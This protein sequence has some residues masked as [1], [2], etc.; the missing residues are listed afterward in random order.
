MIG[1]M[2]II[3]L[4]SLYPSAECPRE[5][6]FAERRWL[7]MRDRGHEVEVLQP[8][9]YCPPG[10]S[11]PRSRFRRIADRERR[12]GIQVTRPRYLHIPGA[13]IGNARRFARAGSR[14][15]AALAPELV[16]CDYAWPAAAACAR[17]KNSGA[18]VVVSARGSDVLIAS[19]SKRLRR[20]FAENLQAADGWCGV[21][22]HLVDAL[23][24]LAEASGRGWLTPNGVDTELFQLGDR[25]EARIDLKIPTDGPLLLNV[26]HLIPRKDP[27]LALEAFRFVRSRHPQARLVYVGEGELRPELE[28]KIDSSGLAGQVGLV[29]DVA[30]EQLAKWF[31]AADLLLLCSSFEGRPNVVL[32]ALASG[33]PVVATAARGTSEL[34]EP[35]RPEFV[36]D[37]RRPE[38]IGDRVLDVMENRPESRTLRDLVADED[39]DSAARR[40][41]RCLDAA[42]ARRSDS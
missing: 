39:W 14:A 22:Q 40:L 6:I 27:L 2:R 21:A 38:V 17:L 3:V 16:V 19:S 41:E 33:R 36:V 1:S 24:Q 25:G 4:T 30:P 10:I 7:S 15:A 37:S 34:L 12:S 26:G 20:V 35:V 5:G 28:S 29:G 32:E 31:A 9:P 13:A 8:V 18:S 42:C 11:G 23:D